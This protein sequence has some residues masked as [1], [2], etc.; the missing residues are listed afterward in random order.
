MLLVAPLALLV[1]YVLVQRRRHTQVLR[2]TSVDLLDSV[3]PQRSGLAAARAGGGHAAVA[4]RARPSR[5]PQPAHGDAHARGPRDDHAHPRHL[6]VDDR[7]RCRAEPA[8]GGRGA[9][10]RSSSRTSRRGSRSASSPSTRRPP[11]RP[12]DH[13]PRPVLDGHRV[14]DVGAGT[15]TADGIRDVA[16]RDRRRCPRAPPD[17]PAPAAIV[18]M[19]DGTPTIGDG[20]RPRREAADAAAQRGQGAGGTDRHDRVRHHRRHGRRPRPGRPGPIRPRRR[21]PRIAAGQR[22]PVVHGR[23]RRPARLDLRPDRPRRRLHGADPGPD[24]GLRGRRPPR[25][26]PG[27]G[28]R[29]ALDPAAGLTTARRAFGRSLPGPAGPLRPPDPGVSPTPTARA[30][31]RAAVVSRGRRPPRLPQPHPCRQR[32]CVGRWQEQHP[33][34]GHVDHHAA[35]PG[36]VPRGRDGDRL[37]VRP[38]VRPQPTTGG[39]GPASPRVRERWCTCGACPFR[40]AI[41]QFPTGISRKGPM[42]LWGSLIG[43]YEF[44]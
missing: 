28:R 29:P 40:S 22:R 41:G 38:H 23:D 19:S 44:F 18:L 27:R 8:A 17:K 33:A 7:D 39:R 42:S 15:A 14:A 12:A 6:R 21:W 36:R 32:P 10:A 16:R 26:A 4:R 24:R 20:Q 9:G 3:A 37:L 2:F 25:R 31:P 1:A 5:S 11:R 43:L 35:A 34:A 13:G 30:R